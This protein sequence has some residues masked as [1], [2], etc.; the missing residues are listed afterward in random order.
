MNSAVLR[1]PGF[2]PSSSSFHTTSRTETCVWQSDHGHVRPGERGVRAGPQA[3]LP[4]LEGPP[5]PPQKTE[6]KLALRGMGES[7][8]SAA[9]QALV[10]RNDTATARSGGP[11][12]R[13]ASDPARERRRES[14]GRADSLDGSQPFVEKVA[15]V[16]RQKEEDEHELHCCY[17]CGCCCARSQ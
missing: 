17:R 12:H 10:R 15:L 9:D 14:G 2:A 8:C 11:R 13:R 1:T 5:F 6:Q 4:P 3:S 7:T 16:L